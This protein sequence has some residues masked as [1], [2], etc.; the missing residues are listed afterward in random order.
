VKDSLQELVLV[1]K[2]IRIVR[3]RWLRSC[4]RIAS[5]IRSY[6]PELTRRQA[7]KRALFHAET[8][9]ELQKLLNLYAIIGQNASNLISLVE[10]TPAEEGSRVDQKAA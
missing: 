2:A 10:K 8:N 9:A 1:L 3:S 7:F 6:S 5:Q 4:R